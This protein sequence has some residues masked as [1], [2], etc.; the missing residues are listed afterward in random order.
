LLV[1]R[2]LALVA[3][4]LVAVA[5]AGLVLSDRVVCPIRLAT[6]RPCPACG[7]TRSW[8]AALRGRPRDSLAFHPLGPAALA[9][10]VAYAAGLDQRPGPIA[11]R[12]RRPGLVAAVVA[13]WL[14][15]WLVRLR[16]G[17]SGG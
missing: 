5:P 16:R 2:D 14:G 15:V 12:L 7:V 13:A 8:H 3:I 9:V 6:G 10:V 4:G 17:W 1:E 11:D